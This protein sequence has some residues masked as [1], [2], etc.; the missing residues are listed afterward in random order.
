VVKLVLIVLGSLAFFWLV[1]VPVFE[2]FAPP[3]VVRAYQRLAM[4]LFRSSA[5]FVPGFGVIETTGRR[6]GLPRRTPVGGR[7]YGDTFWFVAGIGRGTYYMRN[8]EADSR[9]RVKALGRWRTGTA[10]LCPDDDARKRMLRVSPVNGLFL[11]IA[12]GDHLS[13]RVDLDR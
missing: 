8:I 3:H 13:V 12:G 4:P 11:L 10:H 6:T 1:A 2:R 5:G 9:V 7:L